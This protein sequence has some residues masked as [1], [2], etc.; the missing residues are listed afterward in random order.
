M[1]RIVLL[2]GLDGTGALFDDFVRAA[3]ATVRCDVVSLPQE[4]LAYTELVDRLAPRLQLGLDTILLAESFSGP[5]AILLAERQRVAALVLCNTFVLPPRS[6]A[7]TAPLTP[8]FH[9][10]MPA[11]VARWFFVGRDAPDDLVERVQATVASVPPAVLAA[12]VASVSSV[13]V[14]D[15]LARCSAPI[16]YLRGTKDRLVPEASVDAVVRAAS[17]P[18]SVVRIP[19][20]HLLLQAAPE[21]AWRAIEDAVLEPRAA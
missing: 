10:P 21:A 5:L 11:V 6:R 3:P 1:R 7:F 9:L 13:N 15:A 8:L 20:P 17:V 2:P 18:V 19:G 16:V 14:A 4:S 12:R